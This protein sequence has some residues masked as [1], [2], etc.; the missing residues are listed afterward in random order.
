MGKRVIKSPEAQE[1]KREK[2]QAQR[3]IEKMA[4]AGHIP[5]TEEEALRTVRVD[6]LLKRKPVVEEGRNG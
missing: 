4:K 5:P 2:R 6:K 1:L 3:F